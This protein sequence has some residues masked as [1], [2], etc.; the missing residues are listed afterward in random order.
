MGF[1][2]LE[3][4]VA[5]VIL[6]IMATMVLQNI[7]GAVGD[8]TKA[9]A[10]SDIKTIGSALELYKLDN[11][12]YPSTQ[13]G[14]SALVT[15]PSGAPEAA[16]YRQGGYLTTGIPNDPWN[17]PYLYLNPGQHGAFDVYT[18]GRDG[19][20]GGE[21]EDTDLGNWSEAKP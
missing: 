9:R 10:R 18:M 12:N 5:V 2:L 16:N 3:I 8:A 6:S 4:I 15:K 17:R 11:F 20:P 1:S 7:G 13:Q 19:K 21:G 14:L